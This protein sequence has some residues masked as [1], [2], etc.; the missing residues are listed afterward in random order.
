MNPF[1]NKE[2]IGGEENLIKIKLEKD[3]FLN[4]F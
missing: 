2:I 3:H 1:A 4:I